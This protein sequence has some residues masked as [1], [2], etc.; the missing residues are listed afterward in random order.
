MKELKRKKKAVEIA[1]ELN[2]S[3]ALI[4]IWSQKEN[5]FCPKIDLA[6]KIYN[7]Y[8]YVVYPYAEEALKGN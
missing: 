1:R 6:R 8:G 5:D 4:S 2:V 3:E 7:Q